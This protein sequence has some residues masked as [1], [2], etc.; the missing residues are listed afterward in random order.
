MDSEFW[1][2]IAEEWII[3]RS[4]DDTMK[5]KEIIDNLFEKELEKREPEKS[6]FDDL[7]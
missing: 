7:I 2:N 6:M 3:I 1:K 5:T 4:V